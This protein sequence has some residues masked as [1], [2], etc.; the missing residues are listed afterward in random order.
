ML[1]E[2]YAFEYLNTI[3]L[4]L[5]GER[6]GLGKPRSHPWVPF[7]DC[8]CGEPMVSAVCKYNVHNTYNSL[9]FFFGKYNRGVRKAI[10]V[11]N[12]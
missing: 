3:P 1:G 10:L 9:L 7:I 12:P 2:D 8:V 4:Q 11:I 5:M 6:K